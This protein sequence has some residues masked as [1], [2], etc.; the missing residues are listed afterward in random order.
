M[1]HFNSRQSREIEEA[2][3]NVNDLTNYKRA[4]SLRLRDMFKMT[5]TQ[6]SSAVG[7]S[8]Q[9]VRQI[10]AD[11][12]KHGNS[13]FN[14]PRKGGRR[15]ENMTIQEEEKLLEPFFKASEE[16]GIVIVSVIQ[17]AYEQRLGRKVNTSTVYRMLSRHGWRKLAPRPKHPK[18]DIKA[19]ETFKKTSGT[20]TGEISRKRKRQGSAPDVPR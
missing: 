1:Y 8:E 2:I 9:N 12:F 13:V 6:I 4:L 15:R 16:S 7:F 19:Q 20:D 11:Y 14:K 10:H 3:S 5:A 18:A 17:K